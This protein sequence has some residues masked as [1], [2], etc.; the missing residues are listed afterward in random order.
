VHTIVVGKSP[1][2]ILVHSVGKGRSI[3]SEQERVMLGEFDAEWGVVM[4][5]RSR[6]GRAIV[7]IERGNKCL[8]IDYH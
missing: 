6:P 3:H 2:D 4:G 5:Q 1:G 8:I 7:E